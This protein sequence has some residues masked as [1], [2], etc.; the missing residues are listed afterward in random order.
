MLRNFADPTSRAAN[1]A[2]PVSPTIYGKDPVAAAMSYD[3]T[4]Y[5]GTVPTWN[6]MGN[7][8]WATSP[9]YKEA[10]LTTFFEMVAFATRNDK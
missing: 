3:T 6:D 10:V 9:T 2:H 1:L 4:Y 8:N 5:K 7:G